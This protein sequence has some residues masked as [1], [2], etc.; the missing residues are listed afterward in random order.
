M[1]KSMIAVVC[2]AF[3]A[4]VAFA[5]EPPPAA[6]PTP[7]PQAEKKEESALVYV[8]MTTSK[9]DMLIELNH[10]KAPISVKN[11][12]SYVD[13]KHYDGTIFHR[14]MKH[15]MIQG[16]GYNDEMLLRPTEPAIKNE[17]GN[18]L[19]NKRGAI[20]MARMTALDSATCQFFINVVDNPNLDGMRYAVFG[21]VIAGMKTVDAIRDTPTTTDSR[22]EKSQPTETITITSVKRL[23]ADAVEA[24]KTKIGE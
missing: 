16:G 23:P 1:L 7:P 19:L 3:V 20:A 14:I 4:A 24:T 11:F 6:E 13:K 17:S 15:F 12:L 10:E 8:V 21:K 2:L 18:G 9:G 22:G 5:V